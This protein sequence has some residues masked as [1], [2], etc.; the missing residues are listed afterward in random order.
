MKQNILV[1]LL[2]LNAVGVFAQETDK[3]E[4]VRNLL[5]YMNTAMNFNK[6]APQEKVYLH[7]DNT[8]YFKGEIIRFK[9]Y[10]TRMDNEK[11]SNISKNLYVELVNPIGDVIERRTL[12]L[13]NGEAEGDIALD[14]IVGPSGFYEVRAFTRYMTNWGTPALFS[15]TFPVFEKPEVY[16]DYANPSIAPENIHHRLPNVRVETSSNSSKKALEAAAKNLRIGIYPEGGDLVVGLQS[17]VAIDVTDEEG[18]H[19]Q[20]TGALYDANKTKVVDVQTDELG[21]GV[22]DFVPNGMKYTLQLSDKKGKT[23]TVDMPE[24]RLEGVTLNL[25]MLKG[26]DIYARLKCSNEVVGRLLGYTVMHNG[27]VVLCDTMTANPKMTLQFDRPSMSGGVNQLTIFNS[28]GRILS[29]R[30]FFIYPEISSNDSIYVTTKTPDLTPCGKVRV[31]IKSQPNSSISFSAT[32]AATMTNGKVGNA[33]TWML[34]ASEVKG[35]IENPDYYFESDDDEHRRNADLLMMVQGWRRY[36]W[37]MMTGQKKV[38][39]AQPYEDGLYI[40]GRL[41]HRK[42]RKGV[43]NVELDAYLYN[44]KGE[45]MKGSAVTDSLGRYAFKLPAIYENWDLMIKSTKDDKPENYIIGIDRH[46]SP[47]KRLLSPYEMVQLPVEKPEQMKTVDKNGKTIDPSTRLKLSDRNFV[48]PTVKVKARRILGDLRVTWFDEKFAKKKSEI[49]YDCDYDTDRMNDLGEVVP[50]FD[51]WLMEKNPLVM[52]VPGEVPDRILVYGNSDKVYDIESMA[53]E[54]NKSIQEVIDDV[55]YSSSER[56]IEL[57]RNGLSYD[58]RPIV[59]IV[60]NSFCTISNMTSP[61]FT[62]YGVNQKSAAIT[63]PLTL[64]EVKS[65]YISDDISALQ[66]FIVSSDLYSMKPVVAYVYTHPKFDI[67]VKGLRRTHFDGYNKPTEFEMD[68]YS[69]LPPMEDFRRTIYWDAN[70]KT[71]ANGMA[72]V[73]FYN[74]YTAKNIFVSAEGVNSDGKF[75]VNE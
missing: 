28:E 66:N 3:N 26:D 16:G 1:L 8:G 67:K 55:M 54:Q 7:F 2:F 23:R 59:W 53:A 75:L 21:R 25:D 13:E 18:Y 44:A 68:D 61:R 70:V 57:Q 14:S 35:Y 41:S 36:D 73:E 9:A 29:E 12:L 19:M 72:T 58:R 56:P 32:D 71:D 65:V 6:L 60:D 31:E 17:R 49:Y 63:M 64:D 5:G 45:H 15:R 10:V 22:F 37:M 4:Q 24:A 43:E 48:L 34:L 39:K 20:T 51:D 69:I 38:D 52:G 47:E 50:N 42:K 27:N 74:N 62:Y 46:F 40:Y 11:K 30:L 33:M